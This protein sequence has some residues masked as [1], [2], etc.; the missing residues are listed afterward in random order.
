MKKK[1]QLQTGLQ[2]K[3]PDLQLENTS[4]STLLVTGKNKLMQFFFIL[5]SI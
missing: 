5:N 3:Q 2:L 4:V 1:T